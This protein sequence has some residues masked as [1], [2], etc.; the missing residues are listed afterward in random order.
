MPEVDPAT[1]LPKET[2]ERKEDVNRFNRLDGQ[3]AR[4]E[5]LLADIGSEK[6]QLIINKIKEHLLNR[7]T[8]LMNED[9][10][11]KSLSRLL[12]DMGVT[13]QMGEDAVEKLAKMLTKQTQ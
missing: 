9:G 12:V 7:I 2:V 6:G 11:C 4:S 13:V 1:G 3:K 10:E 5:Q 8:K